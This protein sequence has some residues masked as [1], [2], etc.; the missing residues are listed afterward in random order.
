MKA[1]SDSGDRRRAESRPDVSVIIPCYNAADTVSDTL[2]SLQHQTCPNWEAVCIDDGST[3]RTPQVLRSFVASDP[4]IRWTR[5]PHRCPAA[6]RNRGLSLATADRA[7]FLDAD[8]L[9]IEPE[10]L[11]ALFE[12]ARTAGDD[13]VVTGGYELL[14]TQGRPLSVFHFPPD[15]TSR[16]TRC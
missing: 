12:R 13:A 9:L 15:R 11:T 6:A 14:D 8:D 5:G 2:D 4:R 1:A 7:L 3:D 10:A 16:L